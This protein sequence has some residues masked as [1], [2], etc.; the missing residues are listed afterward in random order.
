ML[1]RPGLE[2]EFTSLLIKTG[3]NLAYIKLTANYFDTDK[4]CQRVS[5]GECTKKFEGL[6][7]GD[8]RKWIT[9]IFT[10]GLTMPYS[11]H[12]PNRLWLEHLE[13]I[14]WE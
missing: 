7:Y 14:D 11:L 3:N 10:E 8:P 9:G 4:N 12:K 1:H 5:S 6:R 2:R 13:E